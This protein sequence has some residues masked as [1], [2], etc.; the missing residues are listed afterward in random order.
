MVEK[1]IS[2]NGVEINTVSNELDNPKASVLMLHGY[3]EHIMRY[4]HLIHKF[5]ENKFRIMGFDFRGHGKSGGKRAYINSFDEYVEDLHQIVQQFFK[6]GESNFIYAH[7]MGGCV[8]VRYL[9]KYDNSLFTG[10][11]TTG[12]AMKPD[13]SIPKILIKLSTLVAKI[14]PSLP[15]ISLDSSAVSRISEEVYKYDHDPLNYRG[16]T[17]A[18]FGDEFLKAMKKG[19]EELHKITVPFFINH[20]TADRLINPESAQWIYD[21]ISSSDKTLRFWEG[22][23]HE[24]INEPERE[25]VMG[26]IVKWMNDRIH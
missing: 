21:G 22:L 12:A 14:L 18:R 26:E 9:E 6:E 7:S 20:G 1:Q 17:K 5:T 10:V 24:L 16:G 15:T 2:I 3:A 25:E 13:D 19:K 23:Y 8:L 11:I 4:Q